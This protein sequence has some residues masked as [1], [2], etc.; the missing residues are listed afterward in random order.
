MEFVSMNCAGTDRRRPVIVSSVLL[1]GPKGSG[2]V[3]SSVASTSV[4]ADSRRPSSLA[5]DPPESM[6]FHLTGPSTAAQDHEGAR[7]GTRTVCTSVGTS[8]A[9]P[10]WI[11]TT[12]LPDIRIEDFL[13]LDFLA[14]PDR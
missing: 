4:I 10:T 13:S 2:V 9:R 5:M 7:A 1:T 14:S 3:F 6:L 12:A 8:Q 11:L